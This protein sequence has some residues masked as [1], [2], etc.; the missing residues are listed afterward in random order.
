MVRL[1]DRIETRELISIEEGVEA[2]S[3][4]FRETVDNTT[5]N[6]PRLR[7]Y[8]Y[9]DGGIGRRRFNVFS[10]LSSLRG[11][12]GVNARLDEVGGIEG[13]RLVQAGSIRDRK[14]SDSGAG[15]TGTEPKAAYLLFDLERIELVSIQYSGKAADPLP[16]ADF[17][18]A[19]A[20]RPALNTAVGLKALS[21][22]NARSVGFLGSGSF[23]PAHIAV[24]SDVF[25]DLERISVHSPTR[26][27]RE[28]FAEQ[29]NETLEPR[30]EAEESSRASVE[31][32]D[33]I[34][35]CTNSVEPVFDGNWLKPG[36]TVASVVAMEKYF[37]T[38]DDHFWATEVDDETIERSDIIGCNTIEQAI[39]D[40]QGVLW[41]RVQRGLIE[42]DDV[43]E[44]GDLLTQQ[45]V[46]ENDE[47]IAFF[48][49]NGGQGIADLAIAIEH[50]EKALEDDLGSQIELRE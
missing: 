21:T 1:I 19:G 35:C 23:A 22:E 6:G 43:A 46:R 24:L 7:H 42:W 44:L 13:G 11:Y 34:V 36:A 33:I 31:D 37:G 47:Q 29:A 9:D 48:H 2:I 26:E 5:A 15:A 17:E 40:E 12:A 28:T 4:A 45:S 39:R 16:G 10:G 30:I 32:A 18:N 14:D 25:E 8:K 50:H 20:N 38:K 27:N 49:N 3:N 41:D